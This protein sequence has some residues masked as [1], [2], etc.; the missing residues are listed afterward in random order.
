[1]FSVKNMVI[2]RTKIGSKKVEAISGGCKV[3]SV[4]GEKCI[5]SLAKSE[6][7]LLRPSRYEVSQLRR[8]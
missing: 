1:M 2:E 8:I 5:V 4:T 3:V 6:R 7:F